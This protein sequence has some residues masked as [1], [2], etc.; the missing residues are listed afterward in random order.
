MLR[1]QRRERHSALGKLH[2]HHKKGEK[3]RPKKEGEELGTLQ[4]KAGKENNEEGKATHS[5][6]ER[7]WGEKKRKLLLPLASQKVKTLRNFKRGGNQKKKKEEGRG[8]GFSFF[9]SLSFFFFFLDSSCVAE[10]KEG[11]SKNNGPIKINN[12]YSR[13]GSGWNIPGSFE[14]WQEFSKVLPFGRKAS[15]SGPELTVRKR[16]KKKKD[17]QAEE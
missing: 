9:F 16:E 11:P 6:G 1:S 17:K 14:G 8:L 4:K 3:E 7:V 15:F 13:V 5:E 10:R 12:R 2:T